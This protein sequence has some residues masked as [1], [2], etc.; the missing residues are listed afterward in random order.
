MGRG[1][2]MFILGTGSEIPR[3]N[4]VFF[5]CR[6]PWI[7]VCKISSRNLNGIQSLWHC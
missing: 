1:Q 6:L 5:A 7:E 4:V 2:I 3:E